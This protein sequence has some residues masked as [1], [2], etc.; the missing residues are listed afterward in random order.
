MIQLHNKRTH[1]ASE[2]T[3]YT[4]L[5]YLLLIGVPVF[6]LAL[7]GI[8]SRP[9]GSLAAIWPANAFLLGIMLRNRAFRVPTAW[10]VALGS[11]IAADLITSAPLLMAAIL[12]AGNLVGI[13]AGILFSSRLSAPIRL[14]DQKHGVLVMIGTAVVASLAAGCVGAA[15]YPLLFNGTALR[16]YIFWSVTEFVNYIAFLPVILAAPG[17]RQLWLQLRS[18]RPSSVTISQLLPAASVMLLCLLAMFIEGP[19]QLVIP[20]LGLLWC[21]FSYS[22]FVT[23]I[24]TLFFCIWTLMTLALGYI[25]LNFELSS[26]ESLMSW[27]MGVS[28]IALV[29]I[30]VACFNKARKDE[31]EAL[32]WLATHDSLTGALNRKAFQEYFQTQAASRQNF[33]LAL[34]MLDLD[35]FKAIN[36]EYG[37][38]VGDQVLKHFKYTTENCLRKGDVIGRMGGEEFAILLPSC[39]DSELA[40]IAIRIKNALNQNPTQLAAGQTIRITVSIGSASANMAADDMEILINQADQ[41]LY[42]AKRAGRNQVIRFADI[43]LKDTLIQ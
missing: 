36:D 8:A 12:A 39:P 41:A 1:P 35:H 15:A 21:G 29:P 3:S 34:L 2:K 14:I 40:E 32:K 16:G 18:P 23:A 37:H 43:S 5:Q 26:W 30:V 25:T 38:P 22:V 19:A 9:I 4:L 33:P 31:L 17:I 27:R 20:L 11:L 6:I 10:L 24:L 7:L 13:A 42:C 28:L